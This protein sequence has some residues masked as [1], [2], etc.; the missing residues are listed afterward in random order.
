MTSQPF[1]CPWQ[2]FIKAIRTTRCT[3]VATE[4][5][6]NDHRR[7]KWIKKEEDALPPYPSVFL[8]HSQTQKDREEEEEEEGELII[9]SSLKK[10][11]HII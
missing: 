11:Q 4:Q 6:F 2:L 5:W 7:D 9:H 8:N 3:S 1:I 10:S